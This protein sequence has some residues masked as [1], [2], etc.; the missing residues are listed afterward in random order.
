MVY[1]DNSETDVIT[2]VETTHLLRLE[3]RGNEISI[4]HEVGVVHAYH[5]RFEHHLGLFSPEADT[6]KG[7]MGARTKSSLSSFSLV[8]KFFR[9]GF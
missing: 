8:S 9:G 6:P 5:G 4:A 3:S 2:I 1:N 7:L